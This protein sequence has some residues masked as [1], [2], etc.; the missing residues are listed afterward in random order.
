MNPNVRKIMDDERDDF[1]QRMTETQVSY[2]LRN[3][4]VD[5]IPQLKGE[6]DKKLFA[7]SGFNGKTLNTSAKI[8]E[9]LFRPQLMADPKD[10]PQNDFFS[11]V[12]ALLKKNAIT[13]ADYRF[14]H[15]MGKFDRNDL[16]P[17]DVEVG[18][19]IAEEFKGTG[20]LMP[21][22]ADQVREGLSAFS[23]EQA[24]LVEEI[25]KDVS[26]DV[27]EA[28]S[29]NELV[30]DAIQEIHTAAKDEAT[31]AE[32]IAG[33]EVA[34][35]APA[36][37]PTPE[38]GE[39]TDTP[40]EEPASEENTPPVD[41]TD[42]TDS[43]SVQPVVTK[44]SVMMTALQVATEAIP[45]SPLKLLNMTPMSRDT[46][47]EKFIRAGGNVDDEVDARLSS[48]ESAIKL[49]RDPLLKPKFDE[50]KKAATEALSLTRF[51]SEKIYD[52]GLT[53][54]GIFRKHDPYAVECA[55]QITERFVHG[56]GKIA[57]SPT[58]PTNMTQAIESAFQLA[59][60][61]NLK[62]QGKKIDNSL[63][64][65]HESALYGS[66]EEFAKDDKSKLE[67]IVEL[68]GIKMSNVF[69]A[70][71]ARSTGVATSEKNLKDGSPEDKSELANRVVDK[72]EALYGRKLRDDEKEIIYAV[73]AGEEPFPLTNLYEKFIISSGRK[74][75]DSGA[76]F[77]SENLE[78]K[79]RVFTTLVKTLE[80]LH[81]AKGADLESLEAYLMETSI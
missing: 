42:D 33:P 4:I 7:S 77:T 67:S 72:L 57:L 50:I 11:S 24:E 31:P 1:I 48:L 71:F 12:A 63:I 76:N 26:D 9:A 46:M 13:E 10:M 49:D 59:H 6:D 52:I 53:P 54:S 62:L 16:N 28:Q 5:A 38:T 69:F 56:K 37:D 18:M 25:R 35:E 22:L 75:V 19:K 8:V 34:P 23:A 17:D 58:K 3:V 15:L 45:V 80:H 41:D 61:K 81:I 68:G 43:S 40:V 36:E 78:Q 20:Y 27:S 70:D 60:I 44:E 65:A 66:F 30:Q 55:K 73:A 47:V 51:Y 79:A 39:P 64:M 74:A 21:G 32:P 2:V 29:K 14:D